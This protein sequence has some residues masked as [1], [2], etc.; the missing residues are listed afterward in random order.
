MMSGAAR[1]DRLFH[2]GRLH[3]AS[4]DAQSRPAIEGQGNHPSKNGA[5]FRIKLRTLTLLKLLYNFS[6]SERDALTGYSNEWPPCATSSYSF[7]ERFGMSISAISRFLSALS[8]E[9]LSELS[10]HRSQ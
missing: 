3:L 7:I 4:G 5:P 6:S 8:S 10:F 1:D 9:R 2:A